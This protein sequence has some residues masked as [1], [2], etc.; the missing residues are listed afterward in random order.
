MNDI[1]GKYAKFGLTAEVRHQLVQLS[2]LRPPT[3]GA[4]PRLLVETVIIQ[5]GNRTIVNKEERGG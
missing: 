3:D 1:A 2:T 5:D 4:T